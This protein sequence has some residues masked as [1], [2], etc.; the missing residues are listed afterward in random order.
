MDILSEEGRKQIL[1][2][3]AAEY[4]E[5]RAGVLGGYCKADFPFYCVNDK[6]IAML[7]YEN[8]E[9]FVSGIKGKVIN[10]IHPDDR[11]QVLKDIGIDDSYEGKTYE[12][13]Y[14][15]LKKDGSWFWTIDKGKMYRTEDG[16]LASVSFCTDMSAFIRRKE[17]LE[18]EHLMSDAM[19]KHLPG[20]YHRCSPEEGYPFLYIS[21]RFLKILGWT[22]EEIGSKFDNKFLNMVHPADRKAFSGYMDGLHTDFSNL[23][24]DKI[25]RLNGKEGYRWVTDATLEI[26]VGGQ[27]FL[28]GS[29][30]DIT[31][32][33]EERKKIEARLQEEK[34]AAISANDMKSRFL[35]AISHDIRTPINGIQGMLQIADAYP[36]DCKKQGECRE[37]M[38]V[39][40]KYLVSLVNNVLDMDHLEKNSIML[41]EEP[42]NL[43]ELLMDITAITDIQIAANGLHSVVDWKPGY[44]RHRF[45][46]GSAEGLS[47]ILT[48]LNSNAIKYNK[49]GGTVYCR[50]MEKEF[51]GE[52]VWIE[53]VN[54]DTGI[55][56]SEEF[57]EHAFEPYEQEKRGMALGSVKGVGLGLSIV[58]KTVDLM[59]GTMKVESKL[60][61]GTRFTIMLPF[62]LDPD[63]HVIDPH[64]EKLSL[65]G[66]K[67]LLVEDNDLNMEIAKFQLE[68]N[69]VIVYTAI[70]GQEAVEMFEKSEV[71]FYDIILMDMMMPVMSGMDATRHIRAMNRADAAAVPIIAMSANAFEQDIKEG[72]EAGLNAYLV[73]PLDAKKVSDT[74]KQ[75]LANKIIHKE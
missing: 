24:K 58:K 47:R 57:L 52:T 38:W 75:F 59:G 33:M 51:D 5:E 49:K 17:K 36:N 71:G 35:S 28:Q 21:D 41:H 23:Y 29:I 12:T 54:E 15:M 40:T 9:D 13:V 10:T 61:E 18:Q 20:G 60:N 55:G 56:M 46:L 37:K 22:R 73:K 62:Q 63:P 25:Y 66:V 65:K 1:S 2:E 39:A 31:S 43:I 30:T 16:R 6:M 4:E 34:D 69:D 44:I 74:M 3:F 68:Q 45:L 64:Y 50:C 32:F 7:G 42:F 27:T 8:R 53:I 48:N 11:V 67:A 72:M 26:V 14:R 19:L 70:N